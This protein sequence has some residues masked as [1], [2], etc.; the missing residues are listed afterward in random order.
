MQVHLE[1]TLR[2]LLKPV[3]TWKKG[4]GEEGK[5]CREDN[6]G[7]HRSIKAKTGYRLGRHQK[8]KTERS[9]RTWGER[10]SCRPEI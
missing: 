8:G 1:G 10:K 4:K 6:L 7:P 2:T 5:K 9:D 3:A